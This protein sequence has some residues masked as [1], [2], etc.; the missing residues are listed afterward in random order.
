MLMISTSKGDWEAPQLGLIG[1]S[2]S[3]AEAVL[4]DLL[5]AFPHIRLAVTGTCMA[6]DLA[7]NDVVHVARPGLRTPRFG[8]IV[9]RRH[10][11][12]PRLHRLVWDPP[13]VLGAG[14]TR[15]DRAL[16]WDPPIV[17]GDVLG[18]VVWVEGKGRPRPLF[19]GC[20]SLMSGI[21]ARAEM[22]FRPSPGA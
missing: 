16:I 13:A 2:E 8:D 15:A 17:P 4:R 18:T 9:L 19:A 20:R 11:Q 7:P 3:L 5:G 10:P 21:L 12:G 1:G 22:A 14:R 6:P